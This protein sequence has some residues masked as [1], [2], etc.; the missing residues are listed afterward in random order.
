MS[1]NDDFF[2]ASKRY[3]QSR[4]LQGGAPIDHERLQAI[5]KKINDA[6]ERVRCQGGAHGVAIR[7]IRRPSS[8][9][10]TTPASSD[11]GT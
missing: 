5:L 6:M 7:E 1:D 2:A 11:A 8:S 10:L 9:Y 4:I 3:Q